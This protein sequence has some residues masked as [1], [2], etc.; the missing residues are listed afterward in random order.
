M[1]LLAPSSNFVISCSISRRAPRQK[2]LPGPSQKKTHLRKNREERDT[3]SRNENA[4]VFL[5]GSVGC[6]FVL[7]LELLFFTVSAAF[8]LLLLCCFCCFSLLLLLLLLLLLF[9]FA[10]AYVAFVFAVCVAFVACFAPLLEFFL[11]LQYHYHT[12]VDC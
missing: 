1:I 4:T 12:T 8:I 9:S 2:K 3:G 6:C 5:F 11:S 10:F 7:F